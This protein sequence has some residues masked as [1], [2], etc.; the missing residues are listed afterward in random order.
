M[1]LEAIKEIK[2]VEQSAD[3][4]IDAAKISSIEIIKEAKV[5]AEAKYNK[6]ILA[7][8]EEADIKKRHLKKRWRF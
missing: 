6:I 4:I 2:R 8:R 5:E 1:A 7:A 3:E